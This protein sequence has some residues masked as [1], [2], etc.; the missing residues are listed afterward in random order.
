MYIEVQR[1]IY[2]ITYNTYIRK[3]EMSQIN[4]PS[5]YLKKLVG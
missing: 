1:E 2:S 5:I 3:G 4:D